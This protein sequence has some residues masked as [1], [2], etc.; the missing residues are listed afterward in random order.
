MR[1]ARAAGR[2]PRRGAQ[3]LREARLP[4]LL[5]GEKRRQTRLSCGRARRPACRRKV[6]LSD[7]GCGAACCAHNRPSISGSAASAAAIESSS[8]QSSGA[9]RSDART[10]QR[11]A[12]GPRLR[13]SS[14][15][16]D[17]ARDVAKDGAEIAL[18]AR[19]RARER[20]PAEIGPIEV[21]HHARELVANLEL[22]ALQFAKPALQRFD[23][24]F[25]PPPAKSRLHPALGRFGRRHEEIFLRIAFRGPPFDNQLMK[26]H[27]FLENAGDHRIV[28]REL[29]FENA[30][31]IV[32][33]EPPRFAPA[34]SI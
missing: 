27:A 13:S 6:R 5:E 21:A 17:A 30:P 29:E 9:R 3:R 26:L 14:S 15:G 4:L 7:A 33:D 22:P 20:N 32:E 25:E 1:F 18:A 23:L 34:T 2:G 28:S 11:T 10:S 19:H 12:A 31:V 24:R 8:Q 16:S